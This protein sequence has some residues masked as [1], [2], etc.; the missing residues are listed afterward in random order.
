VE[1]SKQYIPTTPS[2]RKIV[3]REVDLQ[4]YEVELRASHEA[5]CF[6]T[7]DKPLAL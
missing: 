6:H 1:I 7:V 4:K 3:R 2:M 5:G